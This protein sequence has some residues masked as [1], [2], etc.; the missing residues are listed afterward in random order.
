M[1]SYI[2]CNYIVP[3]KAIRLHS[4]LFISFFLYDGSTWQEAVIKEPLSAYSWVIWAAELN[5]PNI[6]PEE[7]K[8]TVR[9]IDKAGKVQISEVTEPF[10]E[11]STGYHMI[12]IQA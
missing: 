9:A 7:Y 5:L 11:G 10:P 4:A 12:N 2:P 1:Q 6:Q 8:L 3:S